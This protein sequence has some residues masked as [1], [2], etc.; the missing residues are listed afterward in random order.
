[1]GAPLSE[2]LPL[3][4]LVD[5]ASRLGHAHVELDEDGIARGLFLYQG[6]GTA[7]WPTLSLALLQALDPRAA[8]D[9]EAALA[10][11][12]SAASN[13]SPWFNQRRDFQRIPFAGPAGTITTY[14]YA[15]VLNGR[16]PP[17]ALR[18]KIL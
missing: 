2:I 5:A 12:A 17:D 11:D 13:G 9:H 18:D 3:P 8:H 6:V 14:S 15:A 7:R 16:L 1:P 10:P 4:A